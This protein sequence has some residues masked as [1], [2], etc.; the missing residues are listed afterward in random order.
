MSS[1]RVQ[2]LSFCSLV[3][4]TSI[5]LLT[6][7]GCTGTGVPTGTVSGKATYSGKPVPQGC[8]ISFVSNSGF[9]AVGVVDVK[10]E[11]KLKMDGKDAI[12]VATY[13]IS[14]TVPGNQGPEMTDEDERKFM[15]GDPSTVAKFSQKKQQPQLPEKYADSIK[16]GLIFEVKAGS[17]TF[18]IDLK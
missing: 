15:A 9:V 4:L 1:V 7:S 5:V 17:N 8:S 14:V 10:G 3:A 6:I 18:D 16:S 11:Y 2:L 13:N 12:P